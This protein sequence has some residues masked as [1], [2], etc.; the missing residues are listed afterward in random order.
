[1]SAGAVVARPSQTLRQRRES[2]RASVARSSG[3]GGTAEAPDQLPIR[4]PEPLVKTADHILRKFKGSRPSLIVHL[5][6]TN[7]RFDQQDGNFGY[8][9]PMNIFLKH[10][11]DG[12]VPHDMLEELFA[13]DVPFYDG[14]LIVEVHDNKSN[15]SKSQ[16]GNTNLV[17]GSTM[18]PFSIHNWN[19]HITPSPHVPYPKRPVNTTAKDANRP[20]TA[21][22]ASKDAEDKEN[23]P[24]PGQPASAAQKSPAKG[25]IFTTVLFPTQVTC[26]EEVGILS[27]TPHS[28]AKGGKKQ[29]G[30][31]DGT[32]AGM[33]PPTPLASIP[34][35]PIS[36]RGP[37]AKRQKMYLEGD[38]IHE[39]EAELLRNTEVSLLLEPAKDFREAQAMIESMSHPRHSY[40]LP[41]RKARKRTER[42]M[43]ADEAN[44]AEQ[45]RFMLLGDER[46]NRSV[47]DGSAA[48]GQVG[49]ASFE[50]S[51]NRFKRLE[52]IKMEHQRKQQQK[53]E[54]EAREAAARHQV[55]EEKS[56]KDREDQ[57]RIHQ[58]N[59]AAKRAETQHLLLQQ[60][61]QQHLAQQQQQQHLQA[62]NALIQ[63]AQAQS[64]QAQ[65]MSPR[66][67]AM[68]SMGMA[69]SPVIGGVN[70]TSHGLASHPM[71]ATSSAQGAG[72]PPRPP[73]AV[74]HHPNAQPMAR[75]VSQARSQA[76]ASS[77]ATPQ[78]VHSTPNMNQ[79]IPARN[80]T[81]QPRT[82]MSQGSPVN[83]QGTPMMNRAAT[84]QMG[85]QTHP[86][87]QPSLREQQL[88]NVQQQMRQQHLQGMGGQQ[89]MGGQQMSA[90]Q[91]RAMAMARAQQLAAQAAAQQQA[92]QAQISQGQSPM[93]AMSPTHPHAQMGTPQPGQPQGANMNTLAYQ[94]ALRQQVQE[95]LR[96][97]QQR[98]QQEQQMGSNPQ[99]PQQAT[100]QVPGMN[101]P[102]EGQQ[103]DPQK[104]FMFQRIRKAAADKYLQLAQQHHGNVPPPILRQ[105]VSA[106]QTELLKLGASQQMA[107]NAMGILQSAVRQVQHQHQQQ[108]LQNRQ[109]QNAA[110]VP[111]M[112]N[113]GGNGMPMNMNPGN[114]SN[115]PGN[116]NMGNIPSNPPMNNMAMNPMQMQQ[117]QNM[118]Q[119]AREAYMRQI[120]QTRQ[121]Q[122]LRMQ[123]ARAQS[124]GGMNMGMSQAAGQNMMAMGNMPNMGMQGMQNMGNMNNMG[125]MHMGRGMQ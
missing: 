124:Q 63:K 39:F 83:I 13:A 32:T 33:H 57:A 8:N 2:Q 79:A 100:Q 77:H 67:G 4:D 5:H 94:Q 14:C 31:K 108:Q 61:Q 3:R 28:E 9:S 109:G 88:Q 16:N 91:V 7:W 65:Q 82:S 17:G 1:M 90:E 85:G 34:P 68:T 59:I 102:Q 89:S 36:N 44:A 23:M 99:T 101:V 106:F 46:L 35:T 12:T 112:Q 62:Q 95:Q 71:A 86:S 113:M 115:A 122:M 56:K 87:V 15:A 107:Q 58:Q 20:P 116:M 48:E 25:R 29:P 41:E 93:H 92:Q 80:M 96:T 60:Q 81:P 70:M 47:A 10:L 18:V 73:S 37:N 120:Q 43:A 105:L 110:N 74:S 69:N 19:E 45:E 118:P 103:G 66:L 42:E 27:R 114:M 50:P 55:N 49:G 76:G 51:F 30:G 98:V 52:S 97:Q 40:P 121:Q 53:K 22:G 72:S 111:N 84:P 117:L 24:A 78:M 38:E 119:E 26:H 125:N 104:T 21:K 6:P 123:Q 75:Q 11:R 54:E 64:S